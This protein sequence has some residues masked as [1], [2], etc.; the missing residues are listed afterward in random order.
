MKC[1][2]QRVRLNLPRSRCWQEKAYERWKWWCDWID[3]F[4]EWVG[5]R[6]TWLRNVRSISFSSFELKIKSFTQKWDGEYMS[7]YQTENSRILDDLRLISPLWQFVIKVDCFSPV[8]HVIMYLKC[9]LP[10]MF[11]L[12]TMVASVCRQVWLDC[13]LQE[14]QQLINL[15]IEMKGGIVGWKHRNVL[16]MTSLPFGH[17][18]P[19]LS[20][21]LKTL[22][23]RFTLRLEIFTP[24]CAL[25]KNVRRWASIFS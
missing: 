9:L 19:F 3:G 8:F 11:T 5:H 20:L 1:Q 10:K 21:R 23:S 13:I 7:C 4:C 14:L 18:P 2:N 15:R 24:A 12:M 17:T 16:P 25:A 6:D 22:A